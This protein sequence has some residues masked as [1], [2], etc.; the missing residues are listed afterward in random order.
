MCSNE[1]GDVAQV[2]AD[3]WKELTADQGTELTCW[4][5]RPGDKGVCI[6]QRK[7]LI[8][9]KACAA[10]ARAPLMPWASRRFSH[11]MICLL[12]QEPRSGPS[13]RVDLSVWSL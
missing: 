5:R 11:P 2:Q 6:W 3:G 7:Y 10:V 9:S 8:T 12:F 1:E 13:Q 4:E